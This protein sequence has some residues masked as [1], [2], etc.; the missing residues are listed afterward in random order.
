MSTD[1][2]LQH[3]EHEIAWRIP[4]HPHIPQSICDGVEPGNQEF[5]GVCWGKS[6]VPYPLRFGQRNVKG[7]WHIRNRRTPILKPMEDN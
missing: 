1:L 3:V 2:S 7:H 5:P 4:P 6:I